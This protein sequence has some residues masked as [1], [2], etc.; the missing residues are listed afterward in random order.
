MDAALA[1]SETALAVLE[2]PLIPVQTYCFEFWYYMY[3][4]DIGG[5]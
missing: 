5:E 3:G 1:G 4:D 2:S